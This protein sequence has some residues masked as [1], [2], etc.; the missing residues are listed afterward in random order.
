MR[1]IREN[2]TPQALIS[3]LAL[4]NQAGQD[5]NY[6]EVGLVE[7]DGSSVSVVAEIRRARILDQGGICAYTMMRIDEESCHNE[8]I[9][10]RSR[11]RAEGR[12]EETLEYRNIVACYPKNDSEGACEFGAIARGTRELAVT[13]LDAA[14][15]QRIAFS[16]TS[17]RA[18]AANP[19]DQAVQEMCD[20]VLVLNHD[21]LI[22]RRLEAFD[23]AGVG[24]K[25]NSPI[26]A[27]QAIALA[28]SI[29][30]HRRGN[31]LAPFC[32]AI[33]HAAKTH[34][35]LIEKVRQRR[36]RSRN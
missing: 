4:R 36:R 35:E 9:I 13:P 28:A 12:M 22:Q 17:G 30:E 34:A 32:V 33:S 3:C 21:A 14:C 26:S 19:T 2:N 31:L 20:E 18:D 11:S 5:L 24:T 25:S 6:D 10:P 7:V 15:E 23:R 1:H 16:R 8:H 29:L 27:P